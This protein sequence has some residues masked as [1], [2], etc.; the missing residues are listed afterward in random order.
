MTEVSGPSSSGEIARVVQGRIRKD[1]KERGRSDRL[2]GTA[3][4]VEGRFRKRSRPHRSRAAFRKERGGTR[5]GLG[6]RVVPRGSV[7]RQKLFAP[8]VGRVPKGTRS[9]E[10]TDR[11]A[12]PHG[13][14]G[15]EKVLRA[16]ATPRTTVHA[17]WWSGPR[18]SG[19]D[20][21]SP[22]RSRADVGGHCAPPR[23]PAGDGASEGRRSIGGWGRQHPGAIDRLTEVSAAA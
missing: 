17:A 16:R 6:A 15:S 19:F 1:P 5:R 13:S 2:G 22:T 11:V 9:R 20:L 12:D 10:R 23:T 3:P 14:G 4:P 18:P 21:R 8:R 7:T